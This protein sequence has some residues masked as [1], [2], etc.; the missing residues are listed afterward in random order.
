LWLSQKGKW[1]AVKAFRLT[2]T[3]RN[4]KCNKKSIHEHLSAQ[5]PGLKLTKIAFQTDKYK[6]PF[7]KNRKLFVILIWDIG[8]IAIDVADGKIARQRLS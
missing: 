6:W 1:K 3:E 7:V 8:K 4:Q 5:Y 2:L